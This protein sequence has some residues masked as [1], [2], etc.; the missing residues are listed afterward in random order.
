VSAFTLAHSITLAAHV[1]GVVKVDPAWVEP[2]IAISIAYV[3]AINLLGRNSSRFS[4]AFGFGLLHGL[5]FAGMLSEIGVPRERVVSSLLLFNAGVEA[6][7]V[8]MLAVLVPAGL[9]A[10]RRYAQRAPMLASGLNAALVLIGLG[11]AGMRVTTI[12]P[13]LALETEFAPEAPQRDQLPASA[14]QPAGLPRSVYPARAPRDSRVTE[15]CEAFHELP[16]TRRAACAG[17]KP[18]I[19]LTGECLRTL[20]SAVASGALRFD[21]GSAERCV[22][23]LQARYA[24]CDF[25]AQKAL[26]ALAECTGLWQGTLARGERCR[27]SLECGK[28]SFCRGLSPLDTGVCAAPEAEGARC[29][30]AIDP[31]AAWLPH[32]EGLHA[33]CEGA[34]VC[35]RGRCRKAAA[36]GG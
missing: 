25:M 8:T 32:S 9:Y 36:S 23:A 28:D 18:G 16:R 35:G 21:D 20:G 15:L 19:M 5:G 26:P 12:E 6:G 30:M 2:L 29:G 17:R 14:A 27:S 31:L 22:A 1:L 7:Q 33:E 3:G 10:R 34:A 4:V 24:D 11:W 13:P